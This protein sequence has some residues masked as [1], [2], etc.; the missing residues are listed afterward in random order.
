MSYKSFQVIYDNFEI[1]KDGRVYAFCAG[2]ESKVE[3]TTPMEKGLIMANLFFYHE[4]E[5]KIYGFEKMIQQIFGIALT[6]I[7][8]PTME[9]A[10][11]LF[12]LVYSQIS[13]QIE[14]SGALIKQVLGKNG[15]PIMMTP[16]EIEEMLV[17]RES[18]AEN[19]VETF[20]G[21]T[22]GQCQYDNF[23]QRV[24]FQFDFA[25]AA[26]FSLEKRICIAPALRFAAMSQG[27]W[28]RD[29]KITPTLLISFV[30]ESFEKDFEKEINEIKENVKKIA[31]NAQEG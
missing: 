6:Q 23:G 31:Q 29:I 30:P 26:E 25:W 18:I 5:R 22:I 15:Y 10:Q 2:R 17:L 20:F 3:V 16:Q 9:S 7:E 21:K 27:I 4:L 11:E 13:G 28:L 12:D 1:D 8:N 19:C 14:Y 24:G